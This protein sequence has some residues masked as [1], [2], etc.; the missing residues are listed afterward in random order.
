MRQ[1]GC[2]INDNGGDA[3]HESSWE[4]SVSASQA[5]PT[6]FPA[7]H[8]GMSSRR[9]NYRYGLGRMAWLTLLA[10]PKG[11][12]LTLRADSLIRRVASSWPPLRCSRR[13]IGTPLGS[14]LGG[15]IGRCWWCWWCCPVAAC[16]D[17]GPCW[18][19][20]SSS[21]VRPVRWTD[22]PVLAKDNSA[23]MAGGAEAAAA[24]LAAAAFAAA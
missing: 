6:L 11:S 13:E 7:R 22:P 9:G 20:G 5:T 16:V 8:H 1:F 4:E 21:D 14:A 23:S 17:V 18:V 12:E 24:L 2:M 10:F 15:E 19:E 3:K